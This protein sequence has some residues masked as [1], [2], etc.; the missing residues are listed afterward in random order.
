MHINS[1][2]HVKLIEKWVDIHFCLFLNNFNLLYKSQRGFRERHSTDFALIIMKVSWP[3]ASD[4]GK[5]IGCVMGDFRKAFDLVDHQ[6]LLK[7]IKSY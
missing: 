2:Y 7:T 1:S 4:G 6:F 5:P 3:K